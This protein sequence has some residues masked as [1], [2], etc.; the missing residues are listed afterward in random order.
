MKD[1][2]DKWQSKTRGGY[3]VLAVYENTQPG[4]DDDRILARV[5]KA[6]GYE[7]FWIWCYC[8]GT[9]SGITDEVLFSS[10]YDLLPKTRRV[11]K[12]INVYAGGRLCQPPY[13]GSRLYD[14]KEAA[15]SE[16]SS[17]IW[18]LSGT[19]PVEIDVAITEETK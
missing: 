10:K 6:L 11:T 18:P 7:A 13:V 8:G 12:W 15:I 14:S 16:E 1:V 19:Y 4:P 17:P 3:E 2:R 9:C 5:R